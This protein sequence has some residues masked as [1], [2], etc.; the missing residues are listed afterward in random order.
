[1][2]IPPSCIKVFMSLVLNKTV[3]ALIS[4]WLGLTPKKKK[5]VKNNKNSKNKKQIIKSKIV[6]KILVRNI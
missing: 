5:A 6:H 1:M 3:M 2:P 4:V